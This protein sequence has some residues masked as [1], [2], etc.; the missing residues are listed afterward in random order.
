MS[1][2]CKPWSRPS[3]YMG[4]TWYGWHSAGFGQSRDSDCLERSNFS[5]AS[6]ELLALKTEWPDRKTE[7][8]MGTGYTVE[9][10]RESHWAVGWVEWIAIHSSNTAAIAKATELCERANDYPVLDEDDWS[11]RE[12]TEA[13]E[14]WTNCFDVS[15]RIAY[16]RQHRSQF[17]FHGF[18]DLLGCVR[19]KYFAGYASELLG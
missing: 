11:E 14:V 12:Q 15:E 6:R 13:N 1:H 18:A 8:E 7:D 17:E 16:I 2:E 19:G 9:I 10:V 4:A 3:N 5:V